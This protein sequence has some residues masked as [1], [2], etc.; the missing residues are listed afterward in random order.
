MRV[1]VTGGAGFIGSAVVRA[2]LA[3]GARQV[4]VLDALTYAANPLTLASL[5]GRSDFAFRRGDVA[6]PAEVAAAF[7]AA[8]PQAV[9]H[10]AAETHVDRSIDGAAAFVRSNVVGT[11]VMLDA[12]LAWRRGLPTAG[13]EAFR[14]L[15]VSTDE[16]FG[17][18]G[19]DGAFDET[20]PYAPRS[21]YAASK[22]AADHLVRA[23][24]VTHGL[25]VLL[26]NCSNNYGPFQHPEKLIPMMTLRGL[27]GRELPLYGDGLQVRDWLHVD[28]HARALLRV[29][30]A[31]R[32]GETYLVGARCERPNREVVEGVCAALDHLRPGGAPHAGLVR[33]V[34]DRPGHDRRYAIDP[35][36]LEAELGWAPQIPF[37]EGL[38]QTVAWYLDNPDWWAA[39]VAAGA[40]E[41]RGAAP[42]PEPGP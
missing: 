39:A 9:L 28:D 4:T 15:H 12:A 37:G 7:A 8:R 33:R 14:F 13:A 18:L 22:A 2:L 29:L 41:R 3:A 31:G 17:A 1:L 36:R 5:D 11:Q 40:L 23:W 35:G 20:T 42:D 21:P 19:P 38:A 24:G 10:L 26:T 32:P 25:P 6:E 16:V 34:A 27:Q 30:E